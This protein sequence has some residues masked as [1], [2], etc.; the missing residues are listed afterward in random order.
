M[1]WY[2]TPS[3][4]SNQFGI[5]PLA[6]A[7]RS[8]I[9]ET[10]PVSNAAPPPP[11]N[12]SN[13][14]Q[15]PPPSN[16]PPPTQSAG[17]YADPWREGNWRW[18]DGQQWTAHID[19]PR[20]VLQQP[21]GGSLGT[22]VSSTVPAGVQPASLSTNVKPRLPSFLSVPVVLAAIPSLGL[23]IIALFMSPFPTLLGL[24]TFFIV[25]P[26]L[27]WLDRLEPE[28]W[29]SKVH[30][31]LWGAF[32]AGFISL[33]VNTTV[34]SLTSES[35]AAVASA[36]IIE[37]ITKALAIVWMVRR[38]EI[39][40]LIDGLVYAGWAALGFA[41]IENVSF[42]FLADE[43]DML[44]EVFIGRAFATPFA[45]PLFTAWSGLAI[46][47]AVRRRK[48]LW[49]AT[50]GLLM[51]MGLHAAWN[52]SI[53][54]AENETGM[55]V[56]GIVLLSF[57]VLFILTTIGVVVLRNRD[58]KRYNMLAPAIAARYG[59]PLDRTQ[60]LLN[61]PTR[62]DVRRALPNRRAKALLDAE[63][64]ALTRLAAMLDYDGV[65]IPDQ[66]SRLVSALVAARGSGQ[67]A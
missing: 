54:I 60:M 49:T 7:Q 29:S 56:A 65:P 43:Q 5:D 19:Q 8:S 2:S 23:L 64:S 42:F 18:Y 22:A 30:T 39:D 40:G 62:R 47:I 11:G 20:P 51:A 67:S 27:L 57:V 61:A 41:M 34:A 21:P 58:Q 12:F 37:E 66:E 16:P 33:V 50:W 36:P 10:D 28:P 53:T 52:G 46:G 25:A 26:P 9:T 14:P 3:T 31:F 59:V 13:L 45:H 44:T 24:T 38:R 35:V 55:V 1:A 32:V 4:F 17:W 63:A 6:V 15:P 48:P